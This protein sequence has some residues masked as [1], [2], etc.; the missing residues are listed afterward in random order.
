MNRPNRMPNFY[1]LSHET[2]VQNKP[3]IFENYEIFT[4]MTQNVK[5]YTVAKKGESGP[6]SYRNI[7]EMRA[8]EDI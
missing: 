2:E 3:H 8:V 4:K 1:C 7:I 5:D 6:N